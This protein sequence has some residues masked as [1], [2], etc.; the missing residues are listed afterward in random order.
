VPNS[1]VRRGNRRGDGDGGDVGASYAR[2]TTKRLTGGT[3]LPARG[4]AREGVAGRWGW[5]VS[6]REGG[7]CGAAAHARAGRQWAEREKARARG[8][9]EAAAA[10]ARFAPARGG[11]ELSLFPFIF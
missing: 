9:G 5:L 1:P 2:K 10:W 11:G 3:G 7:E 8:G 6:K 4:S